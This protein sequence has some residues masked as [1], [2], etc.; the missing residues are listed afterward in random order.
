MNAALY[1][2]DKAAKGSCS[3]FYYSNLLIIFIFTYSGSDAAKLSFRKG[4][5]PIKGI[6][7]PYVNFFR[8]K[9]ITKDSRN[10]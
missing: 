6:F 8:A 2:V 9:I 3:K 7:R 10:S 5:A 4:D 1:C